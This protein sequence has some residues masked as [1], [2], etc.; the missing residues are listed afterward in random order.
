[1]R[2]IP[3]ALTAF[4]TALALAACGSGAVTNAP[5][6]P[7]PVATSL[8]AAST[9]ARVCA[10]STDPT[11]V[12]ASVRGN[13]WGAVTAKVGDVITWANGDSV[14][15]KVALDDGSCSMAANIA[16]GGTKSLVF[17]V[18]GSFPFHCT[19]HPSMTGTI[20]IT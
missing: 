16:G 7:G 19:V 18:A 3:R 15:H 6:T 20:R 8:P 14:P 1:M 17:S 12:D 4:A 9:A 13:T 2:T 5:A 11:D 10:D